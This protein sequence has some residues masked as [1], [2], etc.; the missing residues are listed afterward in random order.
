MKRFRRVRE[1]QIINFRSR[2][3]TE[4][5]NKMTSTDLKDFKES[6]NT[7]QTFSNL[8]ET[9]KSLSNK[10]MNLAK[11]SASNSTQNLQKMNQAM[12]NIKKEFQDQTVEEMSDRFQA[13]LQ[14]LLY[15]SSQEE[16][17][18]SQIRSS[19]RNSPRLREFASKQQLLQDQLQS[20]TQKMLELSKE[21]F[22]ITPQIGR[23]IGKANVE[24]RRKRFN[25]Q[26][27]N[28]KENKIM[29]L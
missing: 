23:A 2:K 29:Q 10:N 12:D 4:P 9:I 7:N 1:Y 5:F 25:R 19:S 11:Q 3:L 13:I 21:T 6:D 14:D 8:E 16:E 26:K 15:L 22:S 18:Q 28:S 24:C 27:P 20:V 17:L